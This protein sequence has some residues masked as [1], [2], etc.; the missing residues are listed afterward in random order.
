MVFSL[1]EISG[2]DASGTFRQ[3]HSN[4][5]LKPETPLLRQCQPDWLAALPATT[6]LAVFSWRN[7]FVPPLAQTRM[8][9][10]HRRTMSPYRDANRRDHFSMSFHLELAAARRPNQSRAMRI[11]SPSSATLSLPQ[12]LGRQ[13]PNHTHRNRALKPLSI[14]CWMLQ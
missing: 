7:C 3:R 8:G 11:L 2:R 4:N 13:P 10:V 1:F 5:N 14:C 12:P 9:Q 6:V